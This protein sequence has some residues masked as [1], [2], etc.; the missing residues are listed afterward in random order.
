M[1]VLTDRW[2]QP[3][4]I[5]S[6]WFASQHNH[7]LSCTCA[8]PAPIIIPSLLAPRSFFL[9]TPSVLSPSFCSPLPPF[10]APFP[11]LLRPL[12]SMLALPAPF[13]STELYCI[14][15]DSVYSAPLLQP[16]ANTLQAGMGDLT[17]HHC[18][19]CGPGSAHPHALTPAL[20][21]SCGWWAQG[22]ALV[23]PAP[24]QLAAAAPSPPSVSLRRPAAAAAAPWLRPVK[25]PPA[26]VRAPPPPLSRS[27]PGR[28]RC[29]WLA[30]LRPSH[31]CCC[32]RRSQLLL[33]P[34][35]RRF[36]AARSGRRGTGL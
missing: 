28:R 11:L 27:L 21:A 19:S 17:H 20:L 16:F 25:Q 35:P 10:L 2:L 1:A 6:T 34:P 33:A 31:G 30:W 32:L 15:S 36:W 7:P 26:V 29:C 12:A 3:N 24:P 5:F 9:F 14:P 8:H 22:Q 23:P 18:Q 13:P 4:G